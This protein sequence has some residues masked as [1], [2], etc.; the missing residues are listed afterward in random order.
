[1]AGNENNYFAIVELHKPAESV[2]HIEQLVKAELE[3]KGIKGFY[4]IKGYKY[5]KK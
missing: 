2:G 3:G 4:N 1:M 5:D